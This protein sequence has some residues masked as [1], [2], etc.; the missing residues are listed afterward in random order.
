MNLRTIIYFAI[1]AEMPEVLI[2]L[3][4]NGSTIVM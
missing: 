4:E 2:L 1:K 3:T